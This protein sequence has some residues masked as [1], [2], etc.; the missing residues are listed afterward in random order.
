MTNMPR[1]PCHD[2]HAVTN[3]PQLPCHNWHAMTTMGDRRS[4]LRSNRAG[5]HDFHPGAALFPQRLLVA[6]DGRHRLDIRRVDGP[7]Q[8]QDPRRVRHN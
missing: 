8:A 5:R 1:L 6:D 4:D 7:R 2:Q 3:T